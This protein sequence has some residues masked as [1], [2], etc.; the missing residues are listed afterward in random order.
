[1]TVPGTLLS[2]SQWARRSHRSQWRFSA[3]STHKRAATLAGVCPFNAATLIVCQK[4][5][6]SMTGALTIS[7]QPSLQSCYERFSAHRAQSRLEVLINPRHL[8]KT[9]KVDWPRKSHRAHA[10]ASGF[11]DTRRGLDYRRVDS[12]VFKGS[13][14]PTR[15]ELTGW[16][17][18]SFHTSSLACLKLS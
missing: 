11:E 3:R 18:V 16:S 14:S 9:P 4:C 13:N 6:S 8:G 2:S 7:E 12:S 17:L 15:K 1:M 10:S 5:P